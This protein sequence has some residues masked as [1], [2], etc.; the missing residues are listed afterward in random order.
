MEELSMYQKLFKTKYSL[1]L[2]LVIIAWVILNCSEEEKTDFHIEGN[3]L[4]DSTGT[5]ISGAT[6][7]LGRLMSGGTTFQQTFTDTNGYYMIRH[8]L[9]GECPTSLIISAIKDGYNPSWYSNPFDSIHV[10]CTNDV[11][12]INLYLVP[13][14]EVN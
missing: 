1:I 7:R 12:I 3:V 5:P 6:V 13:L 11:Q 8:I 4:E 14:E 10:R 2:L 9:E